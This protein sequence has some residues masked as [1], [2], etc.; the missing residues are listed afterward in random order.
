MG[1]DGGKYWTG[2]RVSGV[3]GE[4]SSSGKDCGAHVDK[5]PRRYAETVS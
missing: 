2:W 5:S 4:A 3:V 1:G